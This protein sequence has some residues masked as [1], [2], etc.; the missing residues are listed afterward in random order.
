MPNLCKK[1]HLNIL[2]TILIY[3]V[4]CCN[5]HWAFSQNTRAGM[6][7]EANFW[8]GTIFKH[9]SNFKGP[10]PSFS[11]GMDVNLVW[12]TN[13]RAEW[14]QRR[15][16]PTIGLGI[17]YTH[18]DKEVY[19]QGIG[20][21]PNLELPIIRKKNWEWTTRFGMGIGFINKQYRPYAPY[22]D[23]LNNAIG[24]V[25]NNFSL[26]S[27]DLRYHINKH[28]DVQ[29]GLSYTHMSSA[30]YR[31][32]GLGINLI[33]GHLG[34]RYFPNS[35]TPLHIR[36]ELSNL[37][38]RIL[39][40]ARQG[41]AL[42]TRESSGSAATPVLLSALYMSKRYWS[43][44][45]ILVGLEYSYNQNVYDFLR[46]QAIETGNEKSKVWNAGFFVGHEFLYGRVGLHL[47]MGV[48][49]KQTILAKAPIYQRLGM[50]WYLIQKEKGVIKEL[51]ISTLLKTHYAT[52]ELAELGVG[53]GF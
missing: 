44:N 30:R 12:K 43:K 33:G 17:V 2:I 42:V 15:S 36:R 28:W 53:V 37:P 32:F 23:T 50:N 39:I 40:Q 13:G 18:Y 4:S 9:T 19:G 1:N 41:I 25:I 14:Q 31:Q 46:L 11:G 38:N 8:G 20:V 24:A 22:W 5:S 51:Y 7:V 3:V 16:F 10:I 35:A 45:K 29:A 52:A 49:I 6:G 26:L 34:F 21:Y 48:Y 47:Q 27:S